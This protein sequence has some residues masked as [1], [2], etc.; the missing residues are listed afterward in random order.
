M[1]DSLPNTKLADWRSERGITHRA[2]AQEILAFVQKDPKAPPEFFKITFTDVR[3][4]EAHLS[5]KSYD[6]V[7][8]AIYQYY[9]VEKGSFGDFAPPLK[10]YATQLKSMHILESTVAYQTKNIDSLM[11]LVETQRLLI[12]TLRAEN[13]LLSE[14]LAKYDIG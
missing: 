5:R 13:N 2:L 4:A 9:P 14:K 10:E 1:S 7:T 8:S 3:R 6:R 12:E 11:E